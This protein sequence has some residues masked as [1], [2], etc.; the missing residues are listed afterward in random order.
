[1]FVGSGAGGGGGVGEGERMGGGG[2]KGVL[3]NPCWSE[4][5]REQVKSIL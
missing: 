1:M 2:E 3:G 5:P 4:R